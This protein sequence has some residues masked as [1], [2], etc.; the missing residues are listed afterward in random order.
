MMPTRSKSCDPRGFNVRAA[1]YRRYGLALL[2]GLTCAA[3]CLGQVR[4]GRKVPI[5]RSSFAHLVPDSVGVFA[6]LRLTKETHQSLRDY[7]LWSLVQELSDHSSD[8]ALAS[9]DWRGLVSRNLGMPPEAALEELFGQRLAVAAPSWERLGDAVIL[10][11]LKDPKSLNSVIAGKRL[12][13]MEARGKVN[14][15]RTTTGLSVA[16]SGREAAFSQ[17]ASD[18]ALFWDVVARLNEQKP[19]PLSEHGPF[20]ELAGRLPRGHMAY[21]YF[22]D[23]T[24]EDQIAHRLLPEFREGVLAMYV[25]GAGVHF[26][27]QA[28]LGQARVAPPVLPIDVERI[29]RLPDSALLV[30]SGTLDLPGAFRR[31]LQDDSDVAAQY[32]DLLAAVFDLDV[33]EQK[34]IAK[35]NRRAI[36]VWDRARGDSDVPHLALMFESADA[37]DVVE[38][39]A[40]EL[41]AAADLGYGDDLP[42]PV[43]RT[44]HLDA[45]ILTV[46][47]AEVS[48]GRRSRRAAA[49]VLSMLRPSFAALDGWVVAAT[50]PA[51]VRQII[52]ADRGWIPRLGSIRG[53]GLR[54]VRRPENRVTLAVAQPAMA[55]AV[56]S[57]WKSPENAGEPGNLQRLVSGLRRLAEDGRRPTL[58]VAIRQGERA[59]SVQVV[60]VHA[61]MPADGRLHVGDEIIGIE[62]R[63]LALDD[64][65]ADLRQRLV[66]HSDPD[67]MAMRVWRDDRLMEVTLPLEA[68]LAAPAPEPGTADP[69]AALRHLQSVA[70]V[71]NSASYTVY[72]SGADRLHARV[73]LELVSTGPP[74]S[75]PLGN[76]GETVPP[77]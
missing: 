73:S 37:V 49:D 56:L 4:T 51:A 30:W 65:V 48:G 8:Q 13:H 68:G 10:V 3:P 42:D 67:R 36:V 70:R 15:Y 61:S 60:R 16:S 72:R 6:E 40:H 12:A 18:D 27:L 57:S 41:A 32:T 34:V 52:D 50:D 33:L 54:S 11:R 46:N 66:Q 19:G 9:F 28:K 5:S 43:E 35:L 24:P 14:V 22:A 31:L 64:P 26:E 7:G 39:L 25:Q 53:L 23:R 69:L 38:A 75:A 1:V 2:A 58:G 63:L 17:D 47:L 45:E 55:E 76:D 74:R 71:L 59:G 20:G 62:G 77:S 29:Q 44:A 21:L